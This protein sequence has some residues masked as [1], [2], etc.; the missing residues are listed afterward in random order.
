M[1]W[2]ETG[3]S[4][5]RIKLS[6]KLLSTEFLSVYFESLRNQQNLTQTTKNESDKKFGSCKIFSTDVSL[7]RRCFWLAVM[8]FFS[9][10]IVLTYKYRKRWVKIV[11]VNLPAFFSWPSS[12][13]I[14]LV[15]GTYNYFSRFKS[16]WH[17]N[18]GQK[19]LKIVDRKFT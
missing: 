4:F 19:W 16:W 6:Y 17:K 8:S 9:F 11:K 13:L 5:S 14:V 1:I 12:F 15:V 18:L 10:Q 7:G 2:W 3:N